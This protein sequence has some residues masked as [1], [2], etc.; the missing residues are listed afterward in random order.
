MGRRKIIHI[1]CDCYY[2][3]LEVRD[4][5]D[6][7][8]K[9]V[10][11]GGDG[12]RGVLST[13]NYEARAFGVRSAM[14]TARA[15]LLCPSLIVQPSRFDVYRSVSARI[16][17]ILERYTDQIEPLS[18][19]EAFLDVSESGFAQGSATLLAQHL[20]AEIAREVGITV[21]AGVAPNKY[22]AKIASDWNKPDGLWVIPPAQVDEFVR[23]LPVDRLFGVGR[24][25]AERMHRLGYE[26][27]GDLQNI[28]LGQ[29]LDQF[30]RFGSR[31]YQLVRGVDERP[32]KT[33]RQ[34]K[35]LSVETTFATDLPGLEDCLAQLPGLFQE[36]NR[37]LAR[38][39]SLA[40]S[41]DRVF[42]KM[43]FKDFKQ[44]TIERDRPLTLGTFQGLVEQAWERRHEPVRLLG[45]GVRFD[46]SGSERQLSLFDAMEGDTMSD[47]AKDLIHQPAVEH[48]QPVAQYGA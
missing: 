46:G 6:L 47:L 25:T 37:R 43:R 14:P 38:P 21:S 48:V 16:R 30:G 45:L 20:R 12:P 27:C 15:R 42:L 34:R 10:A 33:E 1:D 40:S 24:K 23:V 9:P 19:D 39:G 4:F 5:P 8:G 41:V 29:L 32:V 17:E 7:A 22:L 3:A 31:L 35:S 11:V 28:P 2:A 13:C 26:N 18:L 36:L 44:T